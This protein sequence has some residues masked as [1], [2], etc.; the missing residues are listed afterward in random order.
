MAEATKAPM[1]EATMAPD[2]SMMAE[3]AGTVTL[4]TRNIRSG[5]GTPRFCTAGC[6]EHIYMLA[7]TETLTGVE[8]GPGGV[9]T[10]RTRPC[11]PSPGS[12]P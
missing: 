4:A 12:F 6:S 5:A 11:W 10:R 3:Q 9:L 8:A 7:I 2:T 1:A